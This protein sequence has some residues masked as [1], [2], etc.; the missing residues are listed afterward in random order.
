MIIKW[1]DLKLLKFC[2]INV[3]D[4]RQPIELFIII[5]VIKDL[6]SIGVLFDHTIKVK[7]S[8]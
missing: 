8:F 7:L 6:Q 1:E 5:R 3:K 2:E 4:F